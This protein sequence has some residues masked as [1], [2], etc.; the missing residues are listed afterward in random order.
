MG[1]PLEG[2]KDD[3]HVLSSLGGALVA[4]LSFAPKSRG[5]KVK[6]CAQIA[7]FAGNSNTKPQNK[8]TRI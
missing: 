6:I 4:M 3:I 2:L 1:V 8:H 7:Y 5:L